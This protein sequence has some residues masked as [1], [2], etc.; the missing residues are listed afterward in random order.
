MKC[1]KVAPAPCRMLFSNGVSWPC[2]SS[3][4]RIAVQHA[5]TVFSFIGEAISVNGYDVGALLTVGSDCMGRMELRRLVREVFW[6]RVAERRR[7]VV[8]KGGQCGHGWK[9][10]G[11]HS[12]VVCSVVTWLLHVFVSSG[13]GQ[14]W[15]QR[16]MGFEGIRVQERRAI[17]NVT[18]G[19]SSAALYARRL[20][21]LLS[22]IRQPP[23]FLFLS[24][25]NH[26]F[27]VRET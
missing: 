10:R 11:L 13:F 8:S 22:P 15:S 25:H 18:N 23:L 7:R 3:T 21:S 5:I 16:A 12:S 20:Q 14:D 9:R 19:V 4:S 26:I 2:L 17:R 24:G 27:C 6:G 1:S